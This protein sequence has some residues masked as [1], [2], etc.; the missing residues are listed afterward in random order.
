MSSTRC[1]QGNESSPDAY[2]HAASTPSRPSE[3]DAS[4]EATDEAAR[5]ARRTSKR[6]RRTSTIVQTQRSLA[7][8]DSESEACAEAAAAP[9]CS[10][11]RSN[12][13]GAPC[14][15][16][17][18]KSARRRRDRAVSLK[19]PKA[20]PTDTWIVVGLFLASR[21]Q[22]EIIF[23]LPRLVDSGVP[24]VSKLATLPIPFKSLMASLSPKHTADR[25]RILLHLRVVQRID[26]AGK[27]Y[28]E[29]RFPCTD[30]AASYHL[31]DNAFK[32]IQLQSVTCR[33]Q[34]QRRGFVAQNH[35]VISNSH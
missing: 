4:D 19:V 35:S 10:C 2:S 13:A 5:G 18:P 7:E 15:L 34:S 17:I 29:A 24:G 1:L 32:W 6:A 22:P 27:L 11:R 20:S 28:G 26:A 25:D 9:S 33:E 12:T 16:T 30:I 8:S 23:W 21:D 3:S 31:G 14:A